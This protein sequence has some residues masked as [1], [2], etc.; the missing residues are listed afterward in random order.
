M[1]YMDPM[2]IGNIHQRRPDLRPEAA[3]FP[4]ADEVQAG[5][6][7]WQWSSFPMF[8]MWFPQQLCYLMMRGH[9]YPMI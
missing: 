7:A 8:F 1:P 2:C 9:V 6:F 4:A 3:V 5:N